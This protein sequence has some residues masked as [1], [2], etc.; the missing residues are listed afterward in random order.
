MKKI[1]FIFIAVCLILPMV[2]SC[3]AN[4]KPIETDN[5]EITTPVVTTPEPV[6]TPTATYKTWVV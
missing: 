4:K 1:L 2:V 5:T 3:T 6:V